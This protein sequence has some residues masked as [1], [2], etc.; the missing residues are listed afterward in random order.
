MDRVLYNHFP[1]YECDCVYY[2]ITLHFASENPENMSAK[3]I[4]C[5][6]LN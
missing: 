6:E 1:N 3:C 5:T 2:N 4:T